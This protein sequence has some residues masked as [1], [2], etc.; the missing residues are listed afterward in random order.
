MTMLHQPEITVLMPVRN[1]GHALQP[2]VASI[3]EQSFEDYELLIVDDHSTDF[4]LQGLI[5][6]DPRLRII[7]NP[8]RG[9][10]DALNFGIESAN[11]KWIA[12]MDGDDVAC[13]DRLA[14]QRQY[15]KEHTNIDLIGAQVRIFRDDNGTAPTDNSPTDNAPAQG[16]RH[17]QQWINQLTEPD[18]I[19]RERFIESPIPHPTAFI[20]R[21][22]LKSVGGYRDRGWAEDY[23]LWLRLAQ[24]GIRMGKPD[25]ILL[26]WRDHDGRLSRNADQYS[27]KQFLK[28]KAHFLTRYFRNFPEICIWGAGP[29]GKKLF[30]YLSSN[31]TIVS[32]FIDVHPRRIGASARGRPVRSADEIMLIN[33]PVL[34]AVGS[35]GARAEIRTALTDTG[36]VEG[37]SFVFAM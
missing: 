18:Q 3:L 21:E 12:R 26:H 13:V 6:R 16:Y 15:A 7:Q 2:A 9:L 11:G 36:R 32:Q 19:A 1:A 31:G 24:G 4:A 23:D 30:D 37:D 14:I 35:R 28:L 34:V 8:G 25:G 29:N 33:E 10:V 22:I 17:Y 27:S 5:D 20:R